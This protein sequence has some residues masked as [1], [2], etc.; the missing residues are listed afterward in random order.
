MV[1]LLQQKKKSKLFPIRERVV[2][3]YPCDIDVLVIFIFMTIPRYFLSMFIS[4]VYEI[5]CLFHDIQINGK[6]IY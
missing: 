6:V 3:D 1:L 5:I 4:Y 2:P